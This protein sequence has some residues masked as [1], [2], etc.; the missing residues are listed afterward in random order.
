MEDIISLYRAVGAEEFYDIIQTKRFS[1]LPNWVNVK[2]FGLDFKET[3]SFANKNIN[4]GIVAIFEVRVPKN[5][6]IETGDFTHVDPFIFKS[7]TVE[8]PEIYL[9]KFNNAICELIHRY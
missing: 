1:V 2:Y 3:L 4:L 8:I 5:I 7:G 6:L 9:D